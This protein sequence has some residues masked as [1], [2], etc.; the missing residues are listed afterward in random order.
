M[1]K[2]KLA[3]D[4]LVNIDDRKNF[5]KR[6]ARTFEILLWASII[7]SFL[8]AALAVNN[9]ADKNIVAALAGSAGLI[10]LIARNLTFTKR[11][12]WNELYRIDLQMLL[13]ELDTAEPLIVEEKYKALQEK[14]Q[15]QWAA[16]QFEV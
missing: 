8:T 9:N 15:R 7:T 5:A 1:T 4:I 16:K 10:V 11:S 13:A 12:A 6:T 3:I 14:K 2:E